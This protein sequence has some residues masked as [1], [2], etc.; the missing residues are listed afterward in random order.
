MDEIY[1]GEKVNKS[2]QQQQKIVARGDWYLFESPLLTMWWNIW[3][4]VVSGK[5][6][7]TGEAHSN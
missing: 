6:L 1:M 7:L 5:Y 4:V 2:K 3:S